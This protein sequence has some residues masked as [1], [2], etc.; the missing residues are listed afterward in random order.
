MSTLGIKSAHTPMTL[1]MKAHRTPHTMETKTHMV[2]SNLSAK[3]GMG[4]SNIPIVQTHVNQDIHEPV[5]L[6]HKQ[7]KKSHSGLEKYRK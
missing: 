4:V 1:G 6:T 2:L 7:H 3:G 5:G